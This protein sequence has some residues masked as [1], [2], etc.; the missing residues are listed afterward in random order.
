MT[1][2]VTDAFK[3]SIICFIFVAM[4]E[5][6]MIF[7]RYQRMI[8]GLPEWLNKPLGGCGYCIT[9]Q[10]ALWYFIITKPFDLIDFL[11]FISLSI[12]LI[13]LYEII[14]NYGQ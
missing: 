14:W 5:P 8:S 1:A 13:S 11:F 10:V 12:F 2:L 9:G 3:I 4:G 7:A 6:G